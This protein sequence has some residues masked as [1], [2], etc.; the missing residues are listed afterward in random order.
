MT[1]FTDTKLVSLIRK[2]LQETLDLLTSGNVGVEKYWQYVGKIIL[3][4]QV[5]GRMGHKLYIKVYVEEEGV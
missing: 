4:R 5:L 2:D 1:N 3:S